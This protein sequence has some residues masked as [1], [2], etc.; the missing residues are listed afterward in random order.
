MHLAAW[1]LQQGHDVHLPVQK[2]EVL[3]IPIESGAVQEASHEEPEQPAAVQQPATQAEAEA[4][5]EDAD[6]TWVEVP[7][8]L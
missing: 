1:L 4:A 6:G 2:E 5:P 8:G 7:E 3:T